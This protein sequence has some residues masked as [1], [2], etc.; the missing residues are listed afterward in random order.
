MTRFVLLAASMLFVLLGATR[1]HIPAHCVDIDRL[2]KLDT[3]VTDTHRDVLDMLRLASANPT[4]GTVL[5]VTQAFGD[6][7]AADTDWTLYDAEFLACVRR[8]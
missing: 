4:H 5:L 8:G 7:V 3:A 6:H 2:D 1:A